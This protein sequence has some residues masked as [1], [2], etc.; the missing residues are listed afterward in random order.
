MILGMAQSH[1]EKKKRHAFVIHANQ[2]SLISL[3][4]AISEACKG[5]QTK[6]IK[7]QSNNTG[8]DDLLWVLIMENFHIYWC[9]RP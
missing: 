2:F 6:Q 7:T 9:V 3:H 1:R 5:I 4:A 8:V